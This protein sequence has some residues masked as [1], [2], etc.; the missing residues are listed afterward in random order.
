MQLNNQHAQQQ[1][2]ASPNT[3]Y[4]HQRYH[5][6]GLQR[7]EIRELYDKTLK[8]FLD[9]D[10]MMVAIS[11]PRKLREILTKT[12]LIKPPSLDIQ[13]LIEEIKLNDS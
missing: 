7:K 3:L 1:R 9:F 12:S 11:R 6:N 4:I 13:H 8:P 10:T 5:P 2:Q